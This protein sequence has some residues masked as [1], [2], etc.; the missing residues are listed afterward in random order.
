MIT[1]PWVRHLCDFWE[2]QGQKAH[3]ACLVEQVAIAGPE[4]SFGWLFS[5]IMIDSL[6]QLEWWEKHLPSSI[7]AKATGTYR[8]LYILNYSSSRGFWFCWWCRNEREVLERQS[9]RKRKKNESLTLIELERWI[10]LELWKEN[11]KGKNDYVCCSQ[12][13]TRLVW[14]WES[15]GKSTRVS[16]HFLLQGIFPDPGTE[17][18]SPAFQV[19]ALISEPPGSPCLL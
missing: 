14:P 6:L 9:L 19:D 12:L 16:C 10:L 2:C 4:D 3:G 5:S 13:P 18:R 15:P 11:I 17:P 8:H 1:I 7:S